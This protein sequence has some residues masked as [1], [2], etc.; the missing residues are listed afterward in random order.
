MEKHITPKQKNTEIGF[1][2]SVVLAGKEE[3]NSEE[4][5]RPWSI[6]SGDA[7]F[8]KEI[9]IHASVVGIILRKGIK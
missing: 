3:L 5:G 2:K 1:L 9:T 8:L 7:K 4:I 6:E